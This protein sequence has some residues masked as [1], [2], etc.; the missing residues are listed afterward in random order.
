MAPQAPRLAAA[1]SETAGP[2]APTSDE[3][4]PLPTAWTVGIVALFGVGALWGIARPLWLDEAFSLTALHDPWRALVDDRGSMALYHLLLWPLSLVSEAPW[5]LRLLSLAATAAALVL[6]VR[7]IAVDHG[8]RAA[9]VAGAVVATAWPV[10][11]HAQEARSYALGLLVVMAQWRLLRAWLRDGDRRAIGFWGVL[12]VAGA[13]VHG[14]LILQVLA[15]AAAVELAGFDA[16][17]RRPVRWGLALGAVPPAALALL[18]ATTLTAYQPPLTVG[19]VTTLVE[20]LVGPG[21]LGLPVLVLAVVGAARLV[22]TARTA[23]TPVARFAAALPVAW[24]LV[25]PVA[26]CAISVVSPK[27]FP[28]YVF[29]SIV[30]VAVLTGVALAAL[31]A[32]RIVLGATAV[33]ALLAVHQIHGHQA[34]TGDWDRVAALV[35]TEAAPGDAVVFPRANRRPPFEVEWA[36]RDDVPAVTA[37]NSDR[38]LGRLRFLEDDAPIAEVV[39]R[40]AGHD[41]VWTVNEPFGSTDREQPVADGLAA[42]GFERVEEWDF[43]MSIVVHLYVRR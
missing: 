9:V 33:V 29:P 11:S 26:L 32:R 5:V 16:A 30:G 24:A 15:Q 22:A 39:A 3:H 21:L 6:L 37:L 10:V 31:P 42:A 18:G 17:T 34:G 25:P 8:R 43:G 28:R 27:M 12:A 13:F 4:A 40:A 38:P 1:R 35:A 20:D 41:R 19:T 2:D 23:A 14:L 36:A 7:G